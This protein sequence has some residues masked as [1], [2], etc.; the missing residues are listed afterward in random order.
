MSRQAS[1][2]DLLVLARQRQLS[3]DEERR[4]QIALQSSRELAVLY[5]AGLQFDDEAGLRPGDEKRFSRLVE[6]AWNASTRQ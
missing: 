3:E 4:F 1:A 5:D 2:E 6:H